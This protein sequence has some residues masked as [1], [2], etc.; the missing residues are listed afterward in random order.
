M[1]MNQRLL[2]PRQSGF[3]PKSV[4]GLY[5]WWDFADGA[6]ITLSASNITTVMDKSPNGYTASQ[7]FANNQPTLASSA[8]NGLS[9]AEY[10]GADD[11]LNA[12]IGSGAGGWDTGLTAFAVAKATGNGGGN[13]GRLFVRDS[14][15]S[16]INGAMNRRTANPACLQFNPPWAVASGSIF[17]RSNDNS[18][19]LDTWLIVGA[20][21]N[22]GTNMATDAEP[23][24]SRAVNTASLS[25]TRTTATTNWSS[26]IR[27]G[28]SNGSGTNSWKGQIGE[29]VIFSRSLSD[30]EVTVVEAYLA[31]KWGL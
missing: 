9:A 22:G 5:A 18:F 7:S 23:R 27:I 26:T 2:R 4:P 19:P 10:D 29:I 30:Q 28:A 20:R 1:G 13:A 6:Q 24:I 25:G 3:N 21:W 16:Q 8:I 14:S 12:T 11:V 31:A 15:G 17:Q